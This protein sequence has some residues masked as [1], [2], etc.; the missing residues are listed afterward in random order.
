MARQTRPKKKRPTAKA[1]ASKNP[2]A[3]SKPAAAKKAKPAP[4]AERHGASGGSVEVRRGPLLDKG[5]G[6]SEEEQGSGGLAERAM[7]VDEI[8]ARSRPDARVELDHDDALQLLV[9]TIL[10]AQCTDERV[11]RV[12]S[13]LFGKY[14]DPGDYLAAPVEELEE[15]IRETGFFR[16]KTRSLRGV[17]E[18][19]VADFGGQVP[20][21]M[22]SLTALP[23]VGRKTANVVLSHCF[24]V[25]GIVVDTHVTRVANRLGLTEQKDATRIERDLS[26]LLP[27]DRWSDFGTRLVLHG[28]YTCRARTPSC[29]EC[30]L[31]DLCPHFA[32]VVAPKAGRQ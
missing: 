12:T 6:G 16:Q 8:L 26:A 15:D 4:G 7:R 23:G 10:A 5:S 17:M 27:E 21:D 3:G 25:A 11:N 24:G 13:R 20:G 19:L 1:P 28:R 18:A 30:P 2:R 22:D 31:M 29:D 9:A 32:E 14:S